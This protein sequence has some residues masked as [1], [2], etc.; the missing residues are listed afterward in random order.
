M[1]NILR[2]PLHNISPQALSDLQEQYPNASVQ[3][4]LSEKPARGGLAETEFWD[5]I[6]QL[7]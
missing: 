4:E 3:I 2:Y 5:L 7:D 1:T 6:A